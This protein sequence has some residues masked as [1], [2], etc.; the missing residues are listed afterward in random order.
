[1]VYI[2]HAH[3]LSGCALVVTLTTPALPGVHINTNIQSA[4][5]EMAERIKKLH[6]YIYTSI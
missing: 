5:V 1:M 6:A 4:C 3:L 2:T